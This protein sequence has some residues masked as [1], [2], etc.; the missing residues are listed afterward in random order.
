MAQVTR[1]WWLL[2]SFGTPLS[3]GLSAQSLNV[4]LVEGDSLRISA[5]QLHFITGKSLERLKDG[6]A[7]VFLGQ[8]SLSSDAGLTGWKR[9]INRF[10]VSYDLWE[11]R[12]SVTR[13]EQGRR[14]V[15]HLSAASAE[16]WCLDNLAIDTA[17]V[18]PDRPFWLRL[19]LRAEDPKD[20]TAVVGEPGINLTRLVEVF[21]RP[22][23]VQQPRWELTTGPLRLADLRRS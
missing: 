3:M 19:E 10:I 4:R 18:P 8:L 22:A 12:F 21:S 15:S 23:R 1:R 11:E 13:T 16:S 7:V 9:A 14:S 6:A 20:L 5:P 17:G 2:A